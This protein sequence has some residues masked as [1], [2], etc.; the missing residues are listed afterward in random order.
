[1]LP[2]HYYNWADVAFADKK[3]LKIL[4]AIFIA[5]PRTISN[6]RLTQLVKTYLA[7]GNVVI[8]IAAEPYID[9]FDG[10]PQF[11][12]LQLSAV[13]PLVNKVA[14]SASLHKL[15]TLTYAQRDL[16]H[17]IA[18]LNF[19]QVVLVNGSWHRSFHT[20]PSYYALMQNHTPYE[21]VSPFADEAEARAYAE[22]FTQTPLRMTR[23]ATQTTRE[24]LDLA[25][26]A[27]TASFDTAFQT[28]VTLGRPVAADQ[29]HYIAHACNT[30]V[31]YRTYAMHY[32]SSRERNFSPPNDQ[33]HYDAVHAEMQ[34][35]ADLLKRQED[36]TGTTLFINLLPC[37][38]CARTLSQTPITE[39]MY[40]LD[41]SDGYAVKLLEAS[42]K[43]V[44]RIV[45]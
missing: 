13:K 12:T 32:G 30:V 15:Y 21:Y 14:A 10:Q 19:A 43:K 5:A 8:G 42:D 1:M 39:F 33:N 44:T 38:N 36:I 41:H 17:I 35:L 4:H 3:P 16:P 24:M 9:G 7:K 6:K 2:N 20:T 23:K 34:L 18:K 22:Q 31:P 26:Q 40:E 25:A 27:A 45:R 28:G 11:E 37:P 29:Y